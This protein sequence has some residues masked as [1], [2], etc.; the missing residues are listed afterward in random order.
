MRRPYERGAILIQVAVTSFVLLALASFAVDLGAAW[1]ARAQAQTAADAGALAGAVA[2]ARDNSNW[3]FATGGIVEQSAIT[4]AQLS[5]NH[6]MS[7][8]GAVQVAAECPSFLTS[9]NNTNCVRV[10]VFRDG[11]NSSTAL[12]TYFANL[13]GVTSQGVLATATAQV[14]PANSSGC[15]RPWF[16]V[17]RY[18]DANNNGVYDA[19]DSYATPGYRVPQDIGTSVQ[20]HLNGG[21]SAYGQLDVGSGGNAIRDAIRNCVTGMTFAIG[22]TAATKPGNTLGPEKQGIDDL[23]AWDPDYNASTRPNG[24]RWDATAKEVVGGCAASGNC[25]C[26]SSSATCP[27]GGTQSP[28]IVQAALCAPTQPTCSGSVPGNSSITIVNILSFFI[29]GYT[30]DSGNLV[31]HAVL[32]ASAGDQNPSGG[33]GPGPSGAFVTI[34]RLVR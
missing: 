14:M 2:L 3:P 33:A 34:T 32:I 4:T 31:I 15:M 30:Q 7:A 12:P 18:T 21:P 22:Q 8:Q 1:Y 16:I 17:D 5:A 10:N 25:A 29:T 19:G 13:F 9:P 28:R 6:V 27:Y 20:F 11:S 26:P 23:M 24:V